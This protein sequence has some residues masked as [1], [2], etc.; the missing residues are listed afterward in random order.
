MHVV[1]T[2]C[3]VSVAFYASRRRGGVKR[4]RDPSV[5]LS[6]GAA[7]VGAQLS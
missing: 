2:V 6:R 1:V 3:R 7:A 4:Y 5:Y